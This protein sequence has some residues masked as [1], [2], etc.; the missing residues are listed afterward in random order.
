[1]R[2]LFC[3]LFAFFASTAHAQTDQEKAQKFA[4]KA[5][6][7][8]EKGKVEDAIE[9]YKKASE[10][11]PD[12]PGPY[13]ELGRCYRDLKKHE[14]A[15]HYVSEYLSRKPD[16]EQ[17]EALIKYTE[18]QRPL[19]SKNKKSL[20]T[21]DSEPQGAVVFLLDANGK[22]T[23]IGVTPIKD[24]P[25][26]TDTVA[27][28]FSGTLFDPYEEKIDGT[29]SQITL[30]S[31]LDPAM[32]A[33]KPNS[34]PTQEPKSDKSGAKP[35]FI[36]SAVSAVGAAGLGFQFN[37]SLD[38]LEQTRSDDPEIDKRYNQ[39]KIFGLSSD[40]LTAIAI[41]AGAFGIIKTVKHKK[42]SKETT[43]V[44]LTPNSI[45]LVGQF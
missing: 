26:P 15:I 30:T 3:L 13:R 32:R 39:V 8:Y 4:E 16:A 21:I 43:S 12:S 10:L 5:A 31:K 28:R 1:M 35:L 44:T 17:R 20:L 24:H 38:T 23:G 29:Q 40:A 25:I 37:R 9:N 22:A 41:G 27:V 7:L 6:T 2:A 19:L 42:S 18:S 36:V 34:Q 45:S 33:P 14:L 11:S